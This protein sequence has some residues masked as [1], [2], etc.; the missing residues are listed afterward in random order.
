MTTEKIV[1]FLKVGMGTATEISD[2]LIQQLITYLL[3]SA[4]LKL[5]LIGAV[6]FILFK[7]CTNAISALKTV[8]AEYPD[9]RFY[10][11]ALKT[12]QILLICVGLILSY[13]NVDGIIKPVTAP[14]VFLLEQGFR[15]IK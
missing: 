6:S 13:R 1:E 15:P 7:A 9:N 14:H 8:L 5:V 11:A 12:I 4:G 3:I 2:T 10:I